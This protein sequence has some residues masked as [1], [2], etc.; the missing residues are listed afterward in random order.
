MKICQYNQSLLLTAFS[1]AVTPLGKTFGKN[2]I[3]LASYPMPTLG[4]LLLY[5]HQSLINY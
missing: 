1:W 3:F 4:T 2:I 5:Y